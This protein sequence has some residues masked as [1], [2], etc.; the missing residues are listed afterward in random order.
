VTA[1]TGAGRAAHRI[2]MAPISMGVGGA[3]RMLITLVE[4]LLARGHTIAVSGAPGPLDDELA[5]LGVE[6]FLLAQRG[7]SP[8]GVAEQSARLAVEF[9]RWRPAVVHAH[10]VRMTAVAAPAARLLRTPVVASFQGIDAGEY[11]PAAR[12]FRL[13]HQ[14]ACVSDDLAGGL[15]E[16]GFPAARLRVIRNV[17]APPPELSAARRAQLRAELGEGPLAVAVG[18]LVPQKNHHRLLEAV[19]QVPGVRVWIVGDGELRAELERHRDELGLA[20]RVSFAGLRR[21]ATEIMAVADVLVFSSD[22]EGLSVAAQEALGVGTPVVSTPVHGMAELLEGRAGIVAPEATAPA[23]AE[24]LRSALGD[25]GRLAAM[26]EAAREIAGRYT[27]GA[28][29]DAYE[30]MYAEAIARR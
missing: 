7:R 18:R 24:A 25:P 15:R 3:E 13:A 11:G 20:G 5:R 17:A 28:M 6:R 19:A 16:R 27:V 9:R 21:D 26:G 1:S 29:T 4:Q 8:L 14:V 10:N 30:A 22:W 12:I 2:W 23:L